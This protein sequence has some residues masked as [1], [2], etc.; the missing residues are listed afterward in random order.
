MV[1]FAG[2]WWLCIMRSDSVWIVNELAIGSM[3][4]SVALHGFNRLRGAMAPL[5]CVKGTKRW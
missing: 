3:V 4:A 5:I 1:L 2:L